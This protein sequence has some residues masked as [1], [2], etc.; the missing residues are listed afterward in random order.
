VLALDVERTRSRT[1]ATT[2]NFSIDGD[3]G[4]D[5]DHEPISLPFY[6]TPQDTDTPFTN[7]STRPNDLEDDQ[8]GDG[9]VYPRGIVAADSAISMNDI[10]IDNTLTLALADHGILM[11]WTDSLI[12]EDLDLYG[13][14]FPEKEDSYDIFLQPDSPHSINMQSPR[15]MEMDFEIQSQNQAR[16]PLELAN[17]QQQRQQIIPASTPP[18]ITTTSETLPTQNACEPAK[19]CIPKIG[20]P[21]NFTIQETVPSPLEKDIGNAY[22][23]QLSNL[24]L[25]IYHQLN[26][27]GG[28]SSPVTLAT[29]VCSRPDDDEAGGNSNPINNAL[30]SSRKF[31]DIINLLQP[32]RPPASSA[33]NIAFSSSDLE[34]DNR[35]TQAHSAPQAA[36]PAT[37]QA[38]ARYSTERTL[39]VSPH[40]IPSPTRLP[41]LPTSGRAEGTGI[42]A[43][44]RAPRRP[45][46]RVQR[47][48]AAERE[49][50]GHGADPDRDAPA[51]PHGEGA[52][53]AA[54]VPGGREGRPLRGHSE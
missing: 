10:D 6:E 36:Q 23:Q 54:G 22:M 16:M 35:G 12:S 24:N 15:R 43:N 29:L 40:S 33:S 20:L 41:T 52:G 45:G 21:F 19:R 5:G 14:M 39:A 18:I 38:P 53:A 49:S 4:G 42:G 30:E 3:G 13:V 9:K 11:P 31:L 17:A 26:R 2:I 47:V 34:P 51:G 1:S 25:T 28:S 44:A 7:T 37:P 50:V 46:S 32:S 27:I 8:G 48:P